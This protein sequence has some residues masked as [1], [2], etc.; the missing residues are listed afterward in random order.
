MRGAL[1]SESRDFGKVIVVAFDV[2]SVEQALRALSDDVKVGFIR[3]SVRGS[4]CIIKKSSS[5]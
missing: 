3:R 1:P 2:L 4:S 5:L